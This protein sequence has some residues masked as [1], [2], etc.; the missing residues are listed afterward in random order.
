MNEAEIIKI[1]K[2][3]Y[4]RY[5]KDKKECVKMVITTKLTPAQMCELAREF[6]VSRDELINTLVEKI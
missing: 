1:I 5:I 6:G 3:L 2:G 4:P